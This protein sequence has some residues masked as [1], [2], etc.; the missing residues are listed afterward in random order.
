MNYTAQTSAGP[1]ELEIEQLGGSMVVRVTSTGDTWNSQYTPDALKQFLAAFADLPDPEAAE[2]AEG[3]LAAWA[4]GGQGRGPTL[5]SEAPK[6]VAA[7][8]PA[9]GLVVLIVCGVGLLTVFVL[10]KFLGADVK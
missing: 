8:A 2:V 1:L 3:V 6:V 4:E 10:L 5:R 9:V 7:F